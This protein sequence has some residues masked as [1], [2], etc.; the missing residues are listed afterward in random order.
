MFRGKGEDED[1]FAGEGVEFIVLWSD[2]FC[3]FINF[4]MNCSFV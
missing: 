1:A 2:H 4:I 3:N